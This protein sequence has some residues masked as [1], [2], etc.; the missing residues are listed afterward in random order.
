MVSGARGSK[1]NLFP[2]PRTRSCPSESSTSSRF[3]AITSAERSPCISIRPTMARSRAFRKLDQKR[4]TSSTERGTTLSLGSR[5]LSLLSSNLG[6]P[7]PIGLR[8]RKG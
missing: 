6:R 4:A 3:K 2:L 8:C 5:T 7:R 1:R